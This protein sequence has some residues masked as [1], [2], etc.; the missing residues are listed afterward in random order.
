MDTTPKVRKEKP[1]RALRLLTRVE[2]ARDQRRARRETNLLYGFWAIDPDSERNSTIGIWDA[3][4]TRGAVNLKYDDGTHL[5]FTVHEWGWRLEDERSA[6]RETF[7]WYTR[8][9]KA[10]YPNNKLWKSQPGERKWDIPKQ[11]PPPTGPEHHAH[12]HRGPYVPHVSGLAKYAADKR[13]AEEERWNE[14][15]RRNKMNGHSST[16]AQTV[17]AKDAE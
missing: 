17:Q 11:S 9:I 15:I 6:L 13:R 14:I 4:I 3:P 1:E 2:D 10:L 12:G 8:Y 7:H 5:K 16:D